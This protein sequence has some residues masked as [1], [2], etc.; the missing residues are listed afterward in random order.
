MFVRN[1]Y[2]AFFITSTHKENFIVLPISDK[3]YTTHDEESIENPKKKP[4]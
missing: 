3:N 1:L 4:L 2:S